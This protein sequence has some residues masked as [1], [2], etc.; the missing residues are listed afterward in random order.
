MTGSFKSR[1]GRGQQ[2]WV[3]PRIRITLLHLGSHTRRWGHPTVRAPPAAIISLFL[4]LVGSAT[5][6]TFLPFH[7]PPAPPRKTPQPLSHFLPRLHLLLSSSIHSST[8][9]RGQKGESSKR[10]RVPPPFVAP[11]RRRSGP[12][13]RGGR[14]PKPGRRC[15]V[16]FSRSSSWPF[17]PVAWRRVG[18]L[19]GG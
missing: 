7:Q 2:S 17:L 15:F 4:F 13:A 16:R 18:R 8:P 11:D 12:T 3:D 1:L 9:G 6:L 10:R 19:V 14:R 5:S